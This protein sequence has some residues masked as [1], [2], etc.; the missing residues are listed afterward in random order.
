MTKIHP[1]DMRYRP[2]VIVFLMFI[3]LERGNNAA[4]THAELFLLILVNSFV[5]C[6]CLFVLFNC[7][8]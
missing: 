3:Y 2:A 1:M 5:L 7:T 6:Y 8:S 4:S